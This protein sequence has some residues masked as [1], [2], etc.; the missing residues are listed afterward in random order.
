[1]CDIKLY[2][3]NL[4]G[5][6]TVCASKSVSHRAVIAAA[7]SDRDITVKNVT[8][9]KDIYATLNGLKALG[10]EFSYE[11]NIVEIKKSSLHKNKKLSFNA[12][13][14]GSTLRFLIPIFTALGNETT[15]FGEGR[16]PSRPLDDYL[17]IFDKNNIEYKK[18]TDYLPLTVNGSFKENTFDVKGDV[19]S[20][21]ITGLMLCA[22][23]RDEEITINI[24]TPLESKGYVDITKKV[25]EDFGCR[26][27]F[28]DN[29]VKVK[30]GICNINEYTVENDWSQAAFF[31]AAGVI[32]GDVTLNDM[33]F[34]SSQGDKEIVAILEKM[35]GK[36]TKGK[37][38]VRV[39]KSVLNGISIDASDIPDLV[40]V[41]AVLGAF[42]KGETRLLNLK[43]LRLKESD[44]IEST[45]AMLKAFGVKC[46]NGDDYIRIF[47]TCILK[48][49]VINS[50]NDHR[51]VMASA[52]MAIACEN[53][54]IKNYKAVDKS[55]PGFFDDYFKLGGKGEIL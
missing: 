33:N 22:L 2:K 12:G 6:V 18:G 13:E 51:I 3:S 25:L 44:R 55:Y 11:N 10:V 35:G 28:K 23:I 27:I 46:E 19:S 7:L 45:M 21:F 37:D 26:V 43:K 30:K 15:F 52:V 38:Y 9:S 49:A 20:Q 36:V 5:E 31:L 47:G 50:F 29:T 8:P 32:S 42:S 34:S 14:S 41:L 4:F 39:E 53:T 16:L 54:I 17:E 40:P 24:T 48:D 1:M